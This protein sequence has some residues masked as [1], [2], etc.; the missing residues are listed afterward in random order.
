MLI[1]QATTEDIAELAR[2]HVAS[3]RETYAGIVPDD[4]L[5]RLSAADRAKS[6]EKSFAAAAPPW[7]TH[8]L[9]QN[10]AIRGFVSAGAAREAE[11][12]LQGELYAIYLLRSVQGGGW[13][14]KLFKTAQNGLRSQGVRDMYLW[15]LAENPTLGFYRH[16]GGVEIGHKMLDIGG[17][18]LKEIALCWKE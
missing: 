2:V 6:W 12:G 17:K 14:Q 13:G 7:Q 18:A 3:W 15:V 5:A 10:G 9:T 8:V 1:R 16:M 11:Y 4:Y